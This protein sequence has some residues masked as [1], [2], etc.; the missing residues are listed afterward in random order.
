MSDSCIH[1]MPTETC[2][3]CAPRNERAVV[4]DTPVLIS[5]QHKGHLGGCEH[6]G[7]DGDYSRWGA[8]TAPGAWRDLANGN[9]ITANA[10]D[11]LG[12]VADSAC[13]SCI[14]RALT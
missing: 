6:K 9:P 11:V 10:G 7:E 1:G 13:L 8:C 12:L 14:E 3:E 2:F 5:P 4:L